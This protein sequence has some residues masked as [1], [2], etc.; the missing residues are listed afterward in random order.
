[1]AGVEKYKRAP[2]DLVPINK[3]SGAAKFFDKMVRDIEADYGGRR[4]LSRVA[5]ELIGAFAGSATALRYLN[6][7]IMLG[8]SI[9]E[10]DLGAY[11]T[12]ASTMLRIGSRLGL[13]RRPVEVQT[14]DQY[15]TAKAQEESA[16]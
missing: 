12:L 13:S 5:S 6:A 16:E 10:L 2:R 9:S 8:E 14:L 4:Q 11:A 3:A 7:Q 1:M 15:L